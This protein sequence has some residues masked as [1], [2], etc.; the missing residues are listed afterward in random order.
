LLQADL[1]RERACFFALRRRVRQALEARLKT[2]APISSTHWRA[3]SEV[4]I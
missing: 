3:L 1:T 2:R 4:A